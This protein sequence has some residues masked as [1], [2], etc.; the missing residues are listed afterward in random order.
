MKTK[1]IKNFKM[2]DEVYKLRRQ[3]IDLIYEAKRGG[4]N[5]PRIEVRVGEQSSSKH[6]NV[7][8]CA[9][10]SGNQM[11]ITKDAIDL[12]LDTL[13]NIVFHEIAH[14]VFGTQYDE[15]CPLMSAKLGTILNKE[16]CLKHLLKYQQ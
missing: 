3:V 8:G 10:M 4:V 9:K 2:N 15:S 13:R 16:D 11:W 5:L 7:L 14:A 1:K 6:K 12:G